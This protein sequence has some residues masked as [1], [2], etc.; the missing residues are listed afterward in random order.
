VDLSLVTLRS[1]SGHFVDC[2]LNVLLPLEIN[3]RYSKRYMWH[4]PWAWHERPVD[5]T[6]AFG[7][8]VQAAVLS[9]T[10]LF[11]GDIYK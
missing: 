10:A 7:H 4:H 9:L 3:E 8:P 1:V 6:G 11:F 2:T 5:Q